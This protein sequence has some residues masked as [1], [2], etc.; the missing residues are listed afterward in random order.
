M[1]NIDQAGLDPKKMP[2]HV[3]LILD[4]NGRWA[5]KRGLPRLKGHQEGSKRVL[6][7]VKSAYALKI[8]H[9]SFYAFSTE[10][11]KRPQSEVMGLMGLLA[12][13]IKDYID[14]MDQMG[15]RL[16]IMGDRSVFSGSLARQLEAALE[17]TKNH[18]KMV[19]NIGL[20]Y[21]G[22][23]EILRACRILAGRVK[24]GDLDPQE[25][26]SAAFEDSLYTRGQPPLDLLIRSSG[27]LRVSNFMLYQ[28]AYAEFWFSQVLWPDFT[29]DVFIQALADYQAR[30][31]R[32]GGI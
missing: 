24:E 4:G 30:D 19:V 18:D 15:I 27:E 22:Q 5:K 3:G 8:P 29:E 17:R 32:F 10:N 9:L 16:N 11:W 21:G 14:E 26:D 25:I 31:R 28:L 1:K 20:N 23:D 2:L 7:I 12:G 6:E 13:F